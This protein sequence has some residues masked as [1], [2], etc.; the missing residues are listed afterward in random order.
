[1]HCS[2][3]IRV[4]HSFPTL[5]SWINAV[6]SFFATLIKRRLK[7]EAFQTITDVQVAITLPRQAQRKAET[8]RLESRTASS[9]LS[10][11]RRKRESNY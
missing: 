7:R 1:L 8:L 5:T 10:N 3:Q 6:E 2:S 9:P 4:F 11:A